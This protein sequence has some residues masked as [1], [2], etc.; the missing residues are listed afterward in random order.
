MAQRRDKKQIE[1]TKDVAIPG[2]AHIVK[3][4]KW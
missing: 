1:M 4:W 3:K 2:V